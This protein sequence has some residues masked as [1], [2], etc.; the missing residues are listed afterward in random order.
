MALMVDAKLIVADEPTTAL[1]AEH[2]RAT[3]D[4]L[5]RLRAQKVAILL[6][7]HDFAVA[8]RMGGDLLVMKE[9]QGIERGEVSAVLS[10]PK[11]PYTKALIEASRLLRRSS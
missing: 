5:V 4:A 2:C 7:T 1:D 8:S 9:G 11:H 3:V 10:E 6:V